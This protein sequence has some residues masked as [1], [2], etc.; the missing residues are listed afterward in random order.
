VELSPEHVE[1]AIR[2]VVEEVTEEVEEVGEAFRERW[3]AAVRDR[4][5]RRGQLPRSRAREG[6]EATEE[7]RRPRTGRLVSV[8][9]NMLEA[10]GPA[11]TAEI[12]V[13]GSCTFAANQCLR[14]EPGRKGSAIVVLRVDASIFSGNYVF[15]AADRE[16]VEIEAGDGHGPI[17]V[18]GNIIEGHLRVRGRSASSSEPDR[19]R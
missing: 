2:A 8:R 16:A 14:G 5:G 18:D 19:T 7:W 17:A 6:A 10:H 15:G 4:W 3:M 9:G 13:E 12:A 1:E 11:H